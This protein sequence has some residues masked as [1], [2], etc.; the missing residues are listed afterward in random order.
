[1]NKNADIRDQDKYVRHIYLETGK[2]KIQFTLHSNLHFRRRNCKKFYQRISL[3]QS[4]IIE[5]KNIMIA[6]YKKQQLL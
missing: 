5:I 2:K 4:L 6:V 3:F 1:M